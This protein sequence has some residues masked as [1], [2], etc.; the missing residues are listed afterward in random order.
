MIEDSK[1]A[2][3]A[4]LIMCCAQISQCHMIPPNLREQVAQYLY[5]IRSAALDSI[6][7]NSKP[8]QRQL[9][10]LASAYWPDEEELSSAVLF[11]KDVLD[12]WG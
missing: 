8:T 4:E 3:L 12:R 11:A 5:E 7:V 6:E 10:M 1:R 2:A 9:L